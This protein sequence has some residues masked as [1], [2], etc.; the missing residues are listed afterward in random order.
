MEKQRKENSNLDPG[1][2]N[3][4]LVE[5][6]AFKSETSQF[7]EGISNKI[8]IALNYLKSIYTSE[9]ITI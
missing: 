8:E 1:E 6:E 9:R 3:L 4:L 5:L 7:N 2:L